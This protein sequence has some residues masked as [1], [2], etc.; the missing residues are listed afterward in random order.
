MNE[1]MRERLSAYLDG[2][3]GESERLAVEAQ[4]ARSEDLRLELEALKA[5]SRSVKGLP[6]QKLPDGFMARLESRR[7]R[8]ANKKEYWILPP[9]MRPLA[10]A[11]STAVVAL[12]VWD[13]TRPPELAPTAGWDGQSAKVV[14]TA[15]RPVADADF[16]ARITQGASLEA[17]PAAKAEKPVLDAKFAK[18]L[19][20]RVDAPGKPLEFVE[21]DRVAANSLDGAVAGG[22]A[23]APAAPKPEPA[24]EAAPLK[25]QATEEPVFTAASDKGSYHASSEEE[26]SAINEKLY[27]GFEA[28]KKKMGIARIIEKSDESKDAR[29]RSLADMMELR[30]PA[31]A[32]AVGDTGTASLAQVSAVRGAVQPR[33]K[34][35]RAMGALSGAGAKNADSPAS[36]AP[37]AVRVVTARSAD[38]LSAAWIGAGLAGDPPKVDFSTQMAVF[39]A[40]PAGCG[41]TETY[42]GK[43]TVTVFY[44][45]EGFT[46]PS[47]RVAAV[48]ASDKR[49]LLKPAP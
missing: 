23:A 22:G 10:F 14:S 48:P 11:L 20:R 30:V 34:A 18:T 41:V 4:L 44:R 45:L 27:E 25:K 16:A 1:E 46:A 19:G 15:D 2:A 9:A 28:E 47:A 43:K 3:L 32:P 37:A 8:E 7:Y 5:V 26:R 17:S 24:R 36:A 35:S 42:V 21:T 38:A 31:A 29:D 40:G 49:V 33:Q 13:H 39:L 12:V 6:R